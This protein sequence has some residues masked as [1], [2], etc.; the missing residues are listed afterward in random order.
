MFAAPVGV[1]AVTKG[2]VGTVV[3]GHDRLG[4]IGKE[5]RDHVLPRRIIFLVEFSVRIGFP[6]DC[7]KSIG[8]IAGGRASLWLGEGPNISGFSWGVRRDVR[9]Y[10][11]FEPI[12]GP[13]NRAAD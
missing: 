5:L 7:Q 10:R 13:K 2:D 8:R 6:V 9:Q 1:D 4:L 12:R 3:L 11:N